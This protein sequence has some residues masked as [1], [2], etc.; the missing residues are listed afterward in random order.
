MKS[1]QSTDK[2]HCEYKINSIMLKEIQ[3]QDFKIT[4]IPRGQNGTAN[5]L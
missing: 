1:L 5:H 2:L 3:V 4:Y